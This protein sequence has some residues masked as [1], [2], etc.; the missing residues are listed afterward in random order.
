LAGESHAETIAQPARDA[1]QRF[2]VDLPAR[3][4]PSL[5]TGRSP[6]LVQSLQQDTKR[7]LFVAGLCERG[8]CTN[9]SLGL[10]TMPWKID[11]RVASYVDA[12][13][14]MG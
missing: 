7:G 10:V 5:G 9:R 12:L 6:I 4:R 3:E 11:F 1:A 13:D 2:A 14:A 8:Y